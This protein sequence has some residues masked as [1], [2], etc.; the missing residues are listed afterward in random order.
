MSDKVDANLPVLILCVPA[1]LEEIVARL[2]GSYFPLQILGW[3]QPPMVDYV[4]MQGLNASGEHI[5]VV[6]FIC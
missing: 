5:S 4:D 1:Y 6:T 3:L 2:Q